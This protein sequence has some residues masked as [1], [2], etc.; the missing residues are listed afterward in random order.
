MI[1]TNVLVFIP[2]LGSYGPQWVSFEIMCP[3]L[4][5]SVCR[6][7]C[8]VYWQTFQRPIIVNSTCS[9]RTRVLQYN[10]YQSARPVI[11]CSTCVHRPR[12][13]RPEW[14]CNISL[15]PPVRFS[16]GL[17]QFLYLYSIVLLLEMITITITI[18]GVGVQHRNLFIP[19]LGSFGIQWGT[20]DLR[21]PS[22][23]PSIYL[24]IGSS[25][26]ILANICAAR[27][28]TQHMWPQATGLA[29]L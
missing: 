15:R 16:V 14:K 21:C 25:T 20:V 8:L 1:Y 28:C 18:N 4:C 3:F 2:T 23:C 7:V 22:L 24:S 17:L 26:S 11:A 9:R 5:L 29:Y 10:L 12:D 19:T 13:K 27:I 6:V